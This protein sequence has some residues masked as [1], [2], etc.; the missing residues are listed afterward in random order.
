MTYLAS[1]ST[2]SLLQEAI[3]LSQGHYEGKMGSNI[4][5][6]SEDIPWLSEMQSKRQ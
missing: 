6:L 2:V 1:P 4:T 5:A 3:V